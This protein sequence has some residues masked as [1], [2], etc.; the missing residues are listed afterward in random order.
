MPGENGTDRVHSLPHTHKK[1]IDKLAPIDSLPR[2][3]NSGFHY[4]YYLYKNILY[5]NTKH[6]K[7]HMFLSHG[8]S[9][10]PHGE[11]W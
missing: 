2:A 3:K 10:S 11:S 4:I 7:N 5:Y 1:G 8:C 6:L 9:K